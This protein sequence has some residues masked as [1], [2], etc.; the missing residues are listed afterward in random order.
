LRLAV[1]EGRVEVV[2]P[3]TFALPWADPAVKMASRFRARI[4]CVTACEHWGLP[5]WDDHET[6]HLVVPRHRSPSQ[7]DPRE[8]ARVVLHRTSTLM[9]DQRWV[10]VAQAIDQAAWCTSPMGQLVIVDAALHAGIVFPADLAHFG[11]GDDRQRAWLRRMASGAAESP[12]E[13]VARVAMVT[14]GFAVREQVPVPGVGRVDFVVEDALVVEVD[15]WAFHGGREAFEADRARD[16][17]LLAR[18]MPV[19]RFTGKQV[20]ADP[21]GMVAEIADVVGRTPRA[22][23]DRRMRWVLGR[24]V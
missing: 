21:C 15:G 9:P 11:E 2:G 5:L 17:R 7:R 12:P 13:T 3:G 8:V 23:F 4:G 22:D 14:A 20:R 18:T 16:R 19:M 1:R 24:S 6:P 10:P